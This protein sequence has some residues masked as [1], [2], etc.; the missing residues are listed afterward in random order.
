MGGTG[1]YKIT[2][3]IRRPSL[4]TVTQAQFEYAH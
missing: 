4:S 1:P 3:N 2:V